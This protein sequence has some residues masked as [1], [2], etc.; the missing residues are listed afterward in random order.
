MAR[1]LAALGPAVL[2]KGG[3]DRG[4]A[5][6]E[7]VDLLLIPAAGPGGVERVVRFAGPRL[8]TRATH[9]TGCTLSAAIAARLAAGEELAEAVRGAIEYVRLAMAAAPPGGAGPLEHFHAFHADRAR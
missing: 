7:V 4:T 2:A 6:G 1:Q 5:A 3:H 9:G 8:A